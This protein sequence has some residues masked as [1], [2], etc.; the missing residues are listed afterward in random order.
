LSAAVDAEL[1]EDR[2]NVVVDRLLGEK[3]L[4]RDLTVTQA[5]TEERQ[6]FEL[7]RGQASWVLA[8]RDSR[9]ETHAADATLAQYPRNARA[10]PWRA[11][12]LELGHA[13]AQ[14]LFVG[15]RRKRKRGLVWAT[16]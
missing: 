11:E 16:D 2:G 9:S 6:N 1:A 3:E 14:R 8:G 4:S 13:T 10:C 15:G 12:L 7:P 5:F